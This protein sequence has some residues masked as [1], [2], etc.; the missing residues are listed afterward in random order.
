MNLGIVVLY[1]LLLILGGYAL[2]RRDGSFNA[3]VGR[4]IEQLFKLVPR[5]L[6]ALAAAGFIAELIP[7]QLISDY[8]GHSAGLGA[9]VIA[10]VLGMIIPAGPVIAF[11]IAAVFAKGGAAVPALVAFLTS[12]SVF[13]AHRIFIYEIPMLGYSFLRMRLI[14]VAPT[15]I[16]AG[17]FALTAGGVA[18]AL[19]L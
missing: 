18:A 5:M 10:S 15:P 8:L 12:W 13:A 6:C 1:G 3:A 16:L 17:I 7:A 4:S 19:N 14:S 11:S 9:I 2:M